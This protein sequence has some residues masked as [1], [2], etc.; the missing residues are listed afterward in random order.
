MDDSYHISTPE[1]VAVKYEL[2]GGGSRFI[3]FVIDFF[4]LSFIL[5]VLFVALDLA[6][7]EEQ[8]SVFAVGGILIHIAYYLIFETISGGA[9]P[10]KNLVQ[11]K[12]ISERGLPLTFRA[13]LIRN[14]LRPLDF[15][16][17]FYILG[18]AL[19]IWSKRNQRFGDIVAGTV[20]IR[21][22][23]IELTD[24]EDTFKDRSYAALAKHCFTFPGETRDLLGSE[25]IWVLKE[26]F[27]RTGELGKAAHRRLQRELARNYARRLAVPVSED[28][29]ERFLEELYLFLRD[30]R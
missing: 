26:F 4:L 12:V 24:L 29:E 6:G 25:D 13:V 22:K 9:S 2:A 14:L 19:I 23:K 30:G 18:M 7:L 1:Q 3:A 20:I 21:S 10:G 5:L 16:P 8:V 11:I 17:F 15:M 28:L 27:L